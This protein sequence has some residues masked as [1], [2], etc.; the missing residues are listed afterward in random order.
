ARA[1]GGRGPPAAVHGVRVRG[2][3]HRGRHPR[4]PRVGRSGAALLAVRARRA[5]HLDGTE[6]RARV[7]VRRSRRE[8]ALALT[9]L[10]PCRGGSAERTAARAALAQGSI[11]YRALSGGAPPPAGVSATK[12][13]ARR[14]LRTKCRGEAT[15]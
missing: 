12:A 8:R 11:Q 2:A 15:G 1:E 3:G 14:R 5:R 9:A 4:P 10:T 7:L 13:N 6:R